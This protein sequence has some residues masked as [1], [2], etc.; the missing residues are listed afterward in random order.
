M[1]KNGVVLK[2]GKEKPIFQHH[3]W[4]FSGAIQSFPSF[5][6][7]GDILPVYSSSGNF[8][9][10]GYFNSKS[11]ISGRMITFDATPPLE[12]LK[13]K[14]FKAYALRQQWFDPST[15]NAYRLINAEGDGIPG[16]I[17]DIYD[18]TVVLQISTKGI[19]RLKEWLIQTLIEILDPQLIYEKSLLPARKEE[20]LTDFQGVLFGTDHS[21]IEIRENGLLFQIDL[22]KSQKTGFFLD[23]R[24]MREWV[25]LLSAG[26][27]VLNAF[28]Y[29]GGFSIYA[30]AG[31]AIQVDSVDISQAAIEAAT[32]HSKLNGFSEVPQNIVCEDVFTFLR[33]D[34]LN[35]NL[36]ILD[37]P[38]FAKKKKDIVQACRG[39]KD[40]NRIAMQ[41][42]PPNSLLLT[43]SC[44]HHV[45]E[46]L[47]QKVLFQASLEAKR[48]VRII[49][50][51]RLAPDHPIDLCHPEGQ[52]LKSFLL[53]IE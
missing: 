36:V 33:T 13:E 3:P 31:K 10:S 44:S 53:A 38:A 4:I 21:P 39:Y 20:G 32:F 15:T 2:G 14:I 30:L 11:T 37:P 12:A 16:L 35:Y 48:N 27:R 41:K 24:E 6:G 40:I 43:C 42:M 29:T 25:R 51:H 23:H 22:A 49:G 50:K 52:Y 34:P 5:Y 26:K 8:L 47:F 9:G 17:V 7:D 46:D 19:E 28:C 45:S 1:M 18:R